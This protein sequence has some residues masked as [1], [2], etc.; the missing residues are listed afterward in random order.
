LSANDELVRNLQADRQTHTQAV[1]S[2]GQFLLVTFTSE[3]YV[4][5]EVVDYI[6]WL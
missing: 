6:I 3:I 4:L 5:L 1:F 2:V